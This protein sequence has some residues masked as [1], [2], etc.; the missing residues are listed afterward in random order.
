MTSDAQVYHCDSTDCYWNHDRA[1]AS[2]QI[3]LDEDHVCRVYILR[4]LAEQAMLADMEAE[5]Q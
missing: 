2:P 4:E 3:D 5:H 1:C